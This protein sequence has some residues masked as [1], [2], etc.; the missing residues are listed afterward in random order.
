MGSISG[1][2]AHPSP[3]TL[4]CMTLGNSSFPEP[5]LLYLMEIAAPVW[6]GS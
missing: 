5:Q 1:S 2:A 4:P 6:H 3:P